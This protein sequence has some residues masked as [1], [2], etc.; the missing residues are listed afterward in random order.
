MKDSLSTFLLALLI[1]ITR[2]PASA[3]VLTS[4][5]VAPPELPIYEQ[6]ILPGDGYLW[7]PGYWAYDK[8]DYYWVPGTWVRPPRVG[9]LWT[10]GYWSWTD[11]FFVFRSGYWSSRIGYYGG[12]N[13][14]YGYSGYGYDGGR[15]DGGRFR[16][17]RAV[18]NINVAN[19]HNTYTKTVI[20]NV[21][22]N[23]VSYHGGDGGTNVSPSAREK[24]DERAKHVGATAEQTQHEKTA[25]VRP[26]LRQS[27]NHGRPLIAATPKSAGYEDSGV[28]PARNPDR[29]QMPDGRD[30]RKARANA[31]RPQ[32]PAAAPSSAPRKESLSTETR[33]NAHGN[34]NLQR[35][36]QQQP[37]QPERPRERSRPERA[38]PSQQPTRDTQP[39][40]QQQ[41]RTQRQEQ[42]HQQKRQQ[43]SAEPQR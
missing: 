15:W 25:R 41:Q 10:P 16:Y 7:T 26:E 17:N 27:F 18:N 6:P 13:Y 4:I 37:M 22:V 5:N 24:A 28:T 42:Q 11:G 9:F 36:K 38:Q 40:Q 34:A 43:P 32:M 8:D 29:N 14:G 21:T 19:I 31:K 20:N 35:E 30:E 12:V 2:V 39:E 23:R 1:S 33:I 3:N